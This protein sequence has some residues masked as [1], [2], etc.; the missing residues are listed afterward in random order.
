MWKRKAETY[1]DFLG[2]GGAEHEGLPLASRRHVVALNDS[3]NLGLETHVQH[4][5]CERKQY[6]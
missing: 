6:Y 5:I 2:E 4:T 3:T 1:L